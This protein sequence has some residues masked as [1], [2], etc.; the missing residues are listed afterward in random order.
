[1]PQRPPSLFA[2]ELPPRATSHHR[3]RWPQFCRL[4]SPELLGSRVTASRWLS[5][6][7]PSKASGVG[8][9]TTDGRYIREWVAEMGLGLDTA[10]QC[11]RGTSVL[12]PSPRPQASL[13]PR[14]ACLPGQASFAQAA[15][16]Y[17]LTMTPVGAAPPAP[18]PVLCG[19][20]LFTQR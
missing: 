13:A 12:Q 6:P 7:G 9:T 1:M 3:P 11:H 10:L 15:A 19:C 17:L 16:A 2:G 5:A 18:F 20:I 8:G 4:E 14:A